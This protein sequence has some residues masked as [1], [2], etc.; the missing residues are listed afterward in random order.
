MV[1]IRASCNTSASGVGEADGPRAPLSGTE[2]PSPDLETVSAVLEGGLLMV[3]GP[4]GDPLPPRAFCIAAAGQPDAGIRIGG[5]ARAR[6]GRVAAVLEAQRAGRLSAGDGDAGAWIEAMLGLGPQPA[7]CGRF[8]LQAE[9]G[10][11]EI[12]RFGDRLRIGIAGGMALLLSPAR[13]ER[14]VDARY[15]LTGP[16]GAPLALADARARLWDDADPEGAPTAPGAIAMQPGLARSGPRAHLRLVQPA[17]RPRAGSSCR[18][19]HSRSPLGER[20][21]TDTS[22]FENS[23]QRVGLRS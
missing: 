6:A 1:S 7:I 16:D 14:P 15:R 20:G 5:D 8:E 13:P 11:C 12:M 22:R 21:A 3:F 4:D 23:G 19:D 2:E 18:C 9:D 17:S 10:A